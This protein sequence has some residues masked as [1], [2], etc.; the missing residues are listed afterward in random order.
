MRF[1]P[2][3]LH[4]KAELEQEKIKLQKQLRELEKEEFLSV[5]N[6][7][8][9][10]RAGFKSGGSL[11]LLQSVL[12]TSNP[13][14]EGIIKIIK[15]RFSKPPAA[16]QKATGEEKAKKNILKTVALEVLTGYLKWKAIELSF[17]GV[18]HLINVR[19]AKKA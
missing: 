9:E 3:Q 8:S 19:K 7:L 12:P 2:R 5:E 13:I 6:M 4:S 18:R 17:K 16:A 14:I 11:G 15:A 10:V 1:Y